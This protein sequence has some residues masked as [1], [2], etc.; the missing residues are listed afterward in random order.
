M[1]CAFSILGLDYG[2]TDYIEIAIYV[3]G[4][5]K[6]V[7]IKYTGYLRRTQVGIILVNRENILVRQS[8]G[9]LM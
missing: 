2:I 7:K 4:I 3:K 6:N 1:N 8:R 5:E 9:A